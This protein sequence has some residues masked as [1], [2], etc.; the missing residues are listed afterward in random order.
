MIYGNSTVYLLCFTMVGEPMSNSKG[1]MEP[2]AM[3]SRA[4][5]HYMCWESEGFMC[6]PRLMYTHPTGSLI[7]SGAD[8]M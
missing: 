1:R 6:K 5:P 4:G 2:D 8:W 3:L 7:Q